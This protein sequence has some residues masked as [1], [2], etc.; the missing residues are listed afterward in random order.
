MSDLDRR[1]DQYVRLYVLSPE[2]VLVEGQA[3]WVQ[4]PL[5]DGLIGIWPGHSPLIGS[6][7]PGTVEYALPDGVHQLQV[8]AGILRVTMEECVVLVSHPEGEAPSELTDD[9]DALFDDLVDS[10]QDEEIRDL[11]EL[12]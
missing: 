11:L 10:L 9:R 12:E 6:L 7:G 8:L 3:L 1:A 2:E 4:V 5:E